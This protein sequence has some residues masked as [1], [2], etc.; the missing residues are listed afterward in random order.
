MVSS[1]YL[2]HR[3]S[4]LSTSRASF[5]LVSKVLSFRLVFQSSKVSIKMGRVLGSGHP[6]AALLHHS[7]S[8]LLAR[9][10]LLLARLH[11][12]P[13]HLRRRLAVARLVRHRR[14]CQT[15]QLLLHPVNLETAL[16]IRCL[17]G[18]DLLGLVGGDVE[19]RHHFANIIAKT[20]WENG[21][22][23]VLATADSV[24]LC[25]AEGLG[26]RS[27]PIL[28]G[29]RLRL[30]HLLAGQLR[31]SGGGCGNSSGARHCGGRGTRTGT[32][33]CSGTGFPGVDRGG[34]GSSTKGLR[35]WHSCSSSGWALLLH[36]QGHLAA[37]VSTVAS[38]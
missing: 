36:D 19:V 18:I 2:G 13:G 11:G 26:F 9:G 8:H 12:L 32:C 1:T 34:G 15:L 22:P 24:H 25:A 23:G 4:H 28:D 31:F 29:L 21:V 16:G 6:A 7:A 3:H 14:V 17:G 10:G 20:P 38:E 30:Q 33:T 27:L 35:D 5:R 37:I